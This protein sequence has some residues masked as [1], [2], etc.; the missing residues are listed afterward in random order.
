TANIV[1]HNSLTP[2][3]VDVEPDY[4]CIDAA[5]IERHVT[6]R[7]R[8]IIPVHVGGLPCEMDAIADI[9]RRRSLAIVEDSAE[10]MFVRYRGRSVGSLG[11]I[12]C[13]STYIAHVISTGVGGVSV[14]DDP[15]LLG[16]MRSV[17]N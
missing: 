7:T 6:P 8:A 1:L 4:Y 10:A 9:A 11:A 15:E 2:V 17:M 14:T 5:Q 3:F 16:I 13:F 12:G